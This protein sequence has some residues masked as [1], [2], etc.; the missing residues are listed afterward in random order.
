MYVIIVFKFYVQVKCLR[1]CLFYSSAM[2]I[3]IEEID[4]KYHEYVLKKL[5]LR[6][7]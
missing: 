5:S 3:A 2:K 1:N 4:F 6:A 7:N